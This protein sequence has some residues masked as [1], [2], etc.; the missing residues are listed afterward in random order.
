MLVSH[1]PM[2]ETDMFHRL[3]IYSC[4]PSESCHA[5]K[6]IIYPVVRGRLEPMIKIKGES[7]ELHTSPKKDND[8]YDG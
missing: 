7:I 4:A 6:I 2:L 3:E 5:S 1:T 8:A